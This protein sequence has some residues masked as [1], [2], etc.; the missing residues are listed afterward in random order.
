MLYAD[1]YGNVETINRVFIYR[2]HLDKIINKIEQF[3]NE[4]SVMI[5]KQEL[6]T[7]F[8]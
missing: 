3:E 2:F 4:L 6:K 5:L 8:F 1:K 7:T